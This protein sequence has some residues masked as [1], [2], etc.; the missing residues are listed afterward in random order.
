MEQAQKSIT[1]FMLQGLSQSE[2]LKKYWDEKGSLDIPEHLIFKWWKDYMESVLARRDRNVKSGIGRGSR[3][4]PRDTGP[5]Y[6]GR[7]QDENRYEETM[8]ALRK[9][10]E[11]RVSLLMGTRVPT[12]RG[13]ISLSQAVAEDCAEAEELLG[14]QAAGLLRNRYE[15]SLHTKILREQGIVRGSGR[16]AIEVGELLLENIS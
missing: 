6:I 3:R 5:Y 8:G 12:K 11:R 9:E 13:A 2:A 10:V 14:R 7:E 1:E 15:M 16:T 4:Q